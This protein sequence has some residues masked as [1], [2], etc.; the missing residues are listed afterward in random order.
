MVK[1][2]REVV[3]IVREKISMF[4]N[5]LSSSTVFPPMTLSGD[6]FSGKCPFP[7]NLRGLVKMYLSIGESRSYFTR[8]SIMLDEK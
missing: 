8:S 2:I 3:K 6:V 4:L 1:I 5:Y 7:T